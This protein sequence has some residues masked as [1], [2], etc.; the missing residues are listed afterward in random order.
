[1]S[2]N[3]ERRRTA[4]VVGTGAGG[5]I[6]AREL[7]KKYQVTILEAGKDFKPFPLPVNKMAG[8]RRTGL[9]L[10]ERMIRLLLPNMLVEKT[11]DMVMVRGI[12]VGGTTT[13]ATGN[14]VRYDGALREMGIDLDAQFDAL[15]RELPIT[16]EHRQKWTQTT[17]DM[18]AI[19]ERMGLDPVVTP[20]FLNAEKCAG[21]GHCAI[22]CP[23]DAKW[24]TRSLV[25]EA[26][27]MGAELIRGCRVTDLEISG[28]EVKGVHTVHSGKKETFRAD[29]VIL[30][31]GG[32]GTPVILEKSGIS[33]SRTLFVDP[34]LCVA[35]PLPGLG[36]DRQ[37]LMPFIS[38]QD[39]YIL[40]PYMDY[41]SFFFNKDWRLPMKDLASIMIKLADE[42]KGGTD[43]RKIDKTMTPLD[44]ERMKCAVEQSREILEQIG[45]PKEQQFLGTLNAGHPGGMLPLTAAEKD[46]LHHP[47]LPGNLYVADATLLPKAMGNPP[48]LTIMAL[49]KKIAEIL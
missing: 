46:T 38:Q 18:F 24:D 12:G 21:C 48:I 47:S 42:E 34:V 27:S 25:S 19:F 45:V 5:A 8:L 16:T 31:A 36:Q 22:G 39:G 23:T 9:F 32:L 49:A 7:Q 14:A 4:I 6:M 1:M 35:G 43:G 15:Y 33:C 26:L 10:D 40:S 11:P 37:L 30:A 44:Q 28:G 41:L 13:L 2:T 20:K 29:L 3:A 17:K